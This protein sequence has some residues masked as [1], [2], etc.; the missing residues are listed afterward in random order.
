V[1]V[2]RALTR[3][4][5]ATGAG[6][7]RRR[8]RGIAPVN[9]EGDPESIQDDISEKLRKKKKKKTQ[10]NAL[11]NLHLNKS[12]RLTHKEKMGREPSSEKKE[13]G[14]RSS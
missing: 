11:I 5:K 1:G 9:R 10:R 12:S 2:V 8:K 4:L 13:G 7:T 14:E 3:V 6:R